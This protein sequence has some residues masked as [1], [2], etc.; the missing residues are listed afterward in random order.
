M[1]VEA[2][3]ET[4]GSIAGDYGD[5]SESGTTGQDPPAYG[6]MTPRG[7]CFRCGYSLNDHFERF[8]LVRCPECGANNNAPD[9]FIPFDWPP[10]HRTLAALGWPGVIAVPLIL[11]SALLKMPLLFLFVN[12]GTTLAAVIIPTRAAFRIT[13]P[14]VRPEQFARRSALLL[15]VGVLWNLALIGAALVLAVRLL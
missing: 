11:A 4:S 15:L 3:R 6:H 10:W 7:R 2:S 14:R 12:I 5:R 1:P 8:G 13:A 9:V